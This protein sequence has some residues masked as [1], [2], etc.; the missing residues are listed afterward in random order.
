MLGKQLVDFLNILW[1][2]CGEASDGGA[3]DTVARLEGDGRC[4]VLPTL[5]KVQG[6]CCHPNGAQGHP[7]KQKLGTLS[8][9]NAR[10]IAIF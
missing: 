1:T 8:M 10:I 7:Q 5:R 4:L 6:H 9:C 3:P 2:P